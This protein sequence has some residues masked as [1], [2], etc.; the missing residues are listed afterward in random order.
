MFHR[1]RGMRSPINSAKHY[2]QVSLSAVAASAAVD[3]PIAV[4][5]EAPSADTPQEV[6]EGAVVK[7]VFV[8][9]WCRADSTTGG[10]I[11][12]SLIKRNGNGADITFAQSIA[13]HDFLDKKN[14]LYHT[15]GLT[16]IAAGVATPFIRQWF[17]IPKGKQRM[18]LGDKLYLNLSSQT[19]G[20]LICGFMT[21]KEYF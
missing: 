20:H 5:V 8:E 19:E 12:L 6:R 17:A 3:V 9:M 13:L 2:V 4:A 18:G 11:L 14:V 1:R 10:T 7:A 16:N 21:Y 15:Q